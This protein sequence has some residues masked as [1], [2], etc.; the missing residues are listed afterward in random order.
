MIAVV[1]WGIPETAVGGIIIGAWIVGVVVPLVADRLY[2]RP[3]APCEPVSA[4]RALKKGADSPETSQDH[5]EE[6][7]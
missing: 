6:A 2:D 7:P 5:T 3:T 4:L 1:V